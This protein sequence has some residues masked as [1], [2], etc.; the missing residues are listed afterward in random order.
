MPD[1]TTNLTRIALF[2]A[3]LAVSSFL[4]IPIG[5]VPLTL[6][7]T[8]ALLAGYAL[9]PSQGAQA[10]LIYTL[11]G[12]AGL[13]IFAAGGGP[14]YIISPTFGFILGFTACAMA[15]G[16]LAR[17]NSK[18]SVLKAYF[19]MLGGLIFLYIP[20]FLWLCLSLHSV[21]GTPEGVSSLI[22]NGLIIPFAGDLLKTLPAAFIGVRL[23][24]L[25]RTE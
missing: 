21:M 24:R 1:R 14:A 16:F 20:G 2:A 4:K 3:I 17:F 15:T 25:I 18:G 8:C 19:I 22:R 12:L 23:R 13:P 7:S 11:A 9:G 6:Q 5:P 10:A